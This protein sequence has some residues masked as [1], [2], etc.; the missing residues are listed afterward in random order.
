MSTQTAQEACS[1]ARHALIETRRLT[2]LAATEADTATEEALKSLQHLVAEA[3][4]DTIRNAK[5]TFGVAVH[6]F[7]LL[8]D[9]NRQL[10]TFF[11][12]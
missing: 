1:R 8:N 10:S 7:E 4:E 2:T 3:S 5:E 12:S 6:A 9:I 11:A